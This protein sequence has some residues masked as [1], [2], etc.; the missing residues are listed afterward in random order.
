[1]GEVNVTDTQIKILT[2]LIA[3]CALIQGAYCTEIHVSSGG[4][5]QEAVDRAKPG[6]TIIVE[7]GVYKETVR[8]DKMY[9]PETFDF[10]YP[11]KWHG[12]EE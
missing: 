10:I 12:K 8:I 9:S 11:S 1:M 5:I 4:S 6:D 7:A 3:L 2:I